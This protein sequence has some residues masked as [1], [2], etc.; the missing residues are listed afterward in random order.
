METDEYRMMYSLEQSYWWFL[1]KQH[2]VREHLKRHF[3]SPS[4][5]KRILDI[6]SGTGII[7]KLLG[8]FGEAYGSEVSMQAIEFLKKRELS[9][10]V[11]SD[12]NEPLPFKDCSFSF[13]TCLD[14][15]EHLDRDLDVLKEIL[16]VCEEGGRVLVTV[17][18][19]M[20]FWSLHDVAL[21]HKRRYTLKRLIH[22]TKH[23]NCKIVSASYYNVLFS[24]PILV[25]R[26]LKAF[27]SK[28]GHAQSDFFLNLPAFLNRAFAILFKVEISLLR[29]IRYPLGISLV[30]VLEKADEHAAEGK[31]QSEA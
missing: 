29:L 7:L 9:R 5:R 13:V 6:G 18:A 16:R 30:L 24:L 20:L 26:K 22:S 4:N 21:H 25:T 11:R 14:V 17:P 3:S 23:L 12:A 31:D 28:Q 10:V 2:L 8:E 19:F 15:L 1:G 27:F